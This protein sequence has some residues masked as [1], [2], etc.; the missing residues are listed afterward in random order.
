[1]N[2]G[3]TGDGTSAKSKLTDEQ[4]RALHAF[5]LRALQIPSEE[6]AKIANTVRL[7]RNG[8]N[9]AYVPVD[10]KLV[11]EK[12]L[13]KDYIEALKVLKANSCPRLTDSDYATFKGVIIKAQEALRAKRK[14]DDDP[15]GAAA[16]GGGG[17]G[18]AAGKKKRKKKEA[19]Q[20]KQLM[21]EVSALKQRLQELQSAPGGNVSAVQ[22]ETSERQGAAE[23]KVTFE[24]AS[25]GNE[26]TAG[27]SWQE[28]L[29][30]TDQPGPSLEA[31]AM[32][33]SKQPDDMDLDATREELVPADESVH[34]NGTKAAVQPVDNGLSPTSEQ[35]Q[36][37]EH[38]LQQGNLQ[39]SIHDLDG[40]DGSD[41]FR[42]G[43]DA[44]NRKLS[45]IQPPKTIKRARKQRWGTYSST[46]RA[47]TALAMALAPAGAQALEF[48][49]RKVQQLMALAAGLLIVVGMLGVV[50]MGL[51]AH[52]MARGRGLLIGMALLIAAAFNTAVAATN[53]FQLLRPVEVQS[54]SPPA[55]TASEQVEHASSGGRTSVW[56]LLG[57]IMVMLIVTVFV[58]AAG[59]HYEAVRVQVRS[60]GPRSYMQ[61][62][63]R[64]EI[65]DIEA[66]LSY[67]P[68]MISFQ[69]ETDYSPAGGLNYSSTV[70]TVAGPPGASASPGSPSSRSSEE[71]SAK[72]DDV[73][74]PVPDS[75]RMTRVK[76]T[77][78]GT[79]TFSYPWAK[80]VT[81]G[82]S[83][84]DKWIAN[85]AK[86]PGIRNLIFPSTRP[87]HAGRENTAIHEENGEKN[88]LSAS[89]R[90]DH[91]IDDFV[92]SHL[93]S[94]SDDVEPDETL[95]RRLSGPARRLWNGMRD[96]LAPKP[97]LDEIQ[98]CPVG[99]IGLHQ[100]HDSIH[101]LAA[102]K[103]FQHEDMDVAAATVAPA[104]APRPPLRIEPN[105][106]KQQCLAGDYTRGRCTAFAFDKNHRYLEEL[107]DVLFD[108]GATPYAL[109][110]A[111]VI[112]ELKRRGVCTALRKLSEEEMK[113]LTITTA[114]GG[115]QPRI[116]A[117][118][119]LTLT[120]FMVSNDAAYG[121]TK[122]DPRHPVGTPVTVDWTAHV[123]EGGGSPNMLVGCS[124]LGSQ[125][126][127]PVS[128]VDK[129]ICTNRVHLKAGTLINTT[130]TGPVM[131]C[132][133]DRLYGV[134]SN[135][136]GLEVYQPAAF[137]QLL[138]RMSPSATQSALKAP[139]PGERT[140]AAASSASSPDSQG[141]T[142]TAARKRHR[143]GNK[144]LP[145]DHSRAR[146]ASA[147]RASVLNE[148]AKL[149]PSTTAT[150]SS[151]AS[152]SPTS[153]S[154]SS[155]YDDDL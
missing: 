4:K 16:A 122:F 108:S 8:D 59:R 32:D 148:H 70:I 58:H 54:P 115:R 18:D 150:T 80:K 113:K 63:A 124:L 136:P 1:M 45:K 28:F 74:A 154:A 104:R 128:R 109:I 20:T 62:A 43:L 125:G 64:Q 21:L 6:Y 76:R 95:L 53:R 89:A 14:T 40:H 66:N 145:L 120:F 78:E 56:W 133:V 55:D 129:G 127:I 142:S 73:E 81:R 100:A 96:V 47:G 102:D 49:P 22:G 111:E 9:I 35:L 94:V 33:V 137:R 51:R 152:T 52:R 92:M 15:N 57:I 12:G 116:V 31:A 7:L 60:E 97:R 140:S 77:H 110:K 131:K 146:H 135:C 143:E 87:L 50:V 36:H 61:F 103:D 25:T 2:Y 106:D 139:T 126:A 107:G 75:C 155:N 105:L 48:P 88:L 144:S 37:V 114:N 71:S 65:F 117:E 67:C 132:F 90:T 151:I 112:E 147:Y 38:Q 93:K 19:Q 39:L 27:V 153:Y 118:A 84:H 86:N 138:E 17:G 121:T 99:V 91:F 68:D 79:P 141:G 119:F 98:V 130:V 46:G 69:E 149:Q 26:S 13:R 11:V 134:E 10:A 123:L 29:D 72:T 85:L 24:S 34:F 5:N 3:G 41:E 101:D 44:K 23:R 42:H 83:K 82:L 30:L